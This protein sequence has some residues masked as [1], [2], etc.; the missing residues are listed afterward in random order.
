MYSNRYSEC[1]NNGP[2]IWLNWIDNSPWTFIGGDPVG[3]L[4]TYVGFEA[5][6]EEAVNPGISQDGD[7]LRDTP[8]PLWTSEKRCVVYDGVDQYAKVTGPT[9][10]TNHSVSFWIWTEGTAST[11][12]F[13]QYG[14]SSAAVSKDLF[15]WLN[16]TDFKYSVDSGSAFATR[17]NFPLYQW[18][19]VV[20][21]YDGTTQRLYTNG[22][23][24]NTG[25]VT[26]TSIS[27]TEPVIIGADSD[28]TGGGS[29][30]SYWKGK[31]SEVQIWTKTLTTNEIT[32]L[33]TNGESGD[34]P[35]TTNLQNHW[36]LDG[37]WNDIEGTDHMIPQN[38]DEDYKSNNNIVAAQSYGN[39]ILP[40]P[41]G[42]NAYSRDRNFR[43]KLNTNGGF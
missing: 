31:Q 21:T 11:V 33:F 5:D 30:G 19:H 6:N 23:S 20:G 35:T 34:D 22:N 25:L 17:T 7:F 42:I 14:W 28:T 9:I 13:Q 2:S 10:P 38:Y 36:P 27:G 18:V 40:F 43:T 4:S 12:C 16:G 37:H 29:M 41:V 24:P 3:Q 39:I 26:R 1:S 8:K 32:Y 15:F